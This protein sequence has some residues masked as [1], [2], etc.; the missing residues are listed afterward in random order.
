MVF[1]MKKFI[2]NFENIFS[3]ANL[4]KA[5]VDYRKGKRNRQSV[6]EYEYRLEENLTE[7]YRRLKNIHTSHRHIGNLL[8]SIRKKELFQRRV[9]QIVLST[10]RCI[11]PFILFMI[12]CLWLVLFP[13]GK[14][15]G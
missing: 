8:F 3:Q 9:W 1:I 2:E 6:A 13:V 4:W 7:L 15:K 5:W 14:V 10:E 11:T 12:V